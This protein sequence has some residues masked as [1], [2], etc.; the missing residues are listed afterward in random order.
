VQIY[1]QMQDIEKYKASNPYREGTKAL[2]KLVEVKPDYEKATIDQYLLR[3]AYMYYNDGVKAYNDKKLAESS[4][5]MKAVEKIHGMD[6]GKRF[7]KLKGFDT[8]AAGANQIMATSAY[9]L[10]NYEESIPLLVSTKNNPITRTP[11]IYE[12]LIDAYNHQKNSAEALAT[13]Q[14][15]RKTFPE[16]ATI[17][18]YELNYYIKSGKQD[19]MVKKLEEAAAKDPNNA[20]IQF[21]IATVYLGMANPKEGKKP[22]NA[23]ELTGKSEAAYKQALRIDPNNASYNY[24]FGALYYNNAID[25][26]VQ[27]NEVTGTSDADTKKYDG[28]KA[29]RDA[30]FG[31]ALPYFEKANEV[32]SKDEGNLKNEDKAT[33]KSTL[34][35]LKEIYARL[36][37][38]DKSQE[39]G[40]KLDAM[41]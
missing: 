39:M 19:E 31:Q 11:S 27:M 40:K 16:D 33:Y 5:D 7:E 35:A 36:N 20:D 34:M 24:N 9:Y 15:A 41:K 30:T 12:C 6:A 18:N 8:V 28:L 26:N 22:A 14:E 38:M 3:S 21:N 23:A 2:L 4:D 37:K 25:F 1:F 10:G 32:L 29:S 13:I 17:R